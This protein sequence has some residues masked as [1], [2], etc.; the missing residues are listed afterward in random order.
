MSVE[1][2][3]RRVPRVLLSKQEAAEAMGMSLRTFERHV[4][5]DVEIVYSGSLRLFPLRGLEAWAQEHAVRPGRR[6]S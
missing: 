2:I 6:A 1:P 4:Q 5:P 3:R